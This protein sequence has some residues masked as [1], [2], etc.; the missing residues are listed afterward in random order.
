MFSRQN[1]LFAVFI[2]I[3][4]ITGNAHS[5]PI[6]DALDK[7]CTDLLGPDEDYSGVFPVGEGVVCVGGGF[8]DDLV[9]SNAD[10]SST[11]VPTDSITTSSVVSGSASIS[12]EAISERLS[13]KRENKTASSN[14]KNNKVTE[15]ISD[16]FGFFFTFKDSDIERKTTQTL[17]DFEADSCW[18]EGN[19]LC[20]D[21]YSFGADIDQ[22]TYLFGFDYRVSNVLLGIAYANA[23]IKVDSSINTS[24]SEFNADQ[25]IFYSTFELPAESYIDLQ[26]G[27]ANG[28]ITMSRDFSFIATI[29]IYGPYLLPDEPLLISN[30]A[31]ASTSSELINASI[32]LGK[33]FHYFALSVGPSVKFSWSNLTIDKYTEKDIDLP[34]NINLVDL[35]EPGLTANIDD[36]IDPLENLLLSN[37]LLSVDEQKI[38]S[39]NASLGLNLTYAISLSSGVLSPMLLLDWI[40]QYDGASELDAA[41]LYDDARQYSFNL[42]SPKTDKDYFLL[43]VGV[44]FVAPFGISSYTLVE[45]YARNDNYEALSVSF[46]VRIEI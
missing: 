20:S 19:R 7:F 34:S 16:R 44:S 21:T 30:I 45:K 29:D 17:A 42:E 9:I 1:L 43:G 28:N 8:V 2:S 6:S 36:I 24:E 37:F 13:E 23:E 40:H 41:F 4:I 10:F 46:G 5:Q 39:F 35:T 25:I 31:K 33:N 38:E 15:Q 14:S 11:F 3:N 32:E 18:G 22:K 26:F 12:N 27:I